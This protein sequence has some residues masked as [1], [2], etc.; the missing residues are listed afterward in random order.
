MEGIPI[1][2]AVCLALA[3]VTKRRGLPSIPFYIIAGLLIGE[4]GFRIVAPD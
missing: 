3:I 2:L 1:A 4:T